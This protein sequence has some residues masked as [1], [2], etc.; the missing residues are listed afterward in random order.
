MIQPVPAGDPAAAATRVVLLGLLA[1]SSALLVG[2]LH[3]FYTRSR[4][5]EGLAVLVG[6]SVVA[7]YL[8]TTAAL[9]EV[10]ADDTDL[11]ALGSALFNVAAFGLAG[12]AAAAGGRAGDRL[13]ESLV[14]LSD[15]PTTDVDVSGLVT[16][17]GRVVTVD[18]PT[19]IEDMEGYDPVDPRTKETLAGATLV[20]PR[21]LTV[22][23]LRER[24]VARL[25]DDYGVGHV[26]LELTADGTVTYLAVG[27]R[28]AGIG[29]TLPP[30]S[31]AV[32][33]RADP[34]NAASAGDLVQVYAPGPEPTRVATAEVRGTASDVVTLAVDAAD[35]GT[36]DGET[37]YR[38]VTLP[39]EPRADREFASLLRSVEET[40]GVATVDAGSSLVGQPVSAVDAAVVAIRTADGTI[41]PIPR[42]SRT[43]AAGESV[44]AIARPDRLRRLDEAARATPGDAGAEGDGEATPSTPAGPEDR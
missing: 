23:E 9:G 8:N 28:E 17:V 14:A 41:E 10:I 15:S 34:A 3:R 26:D 39:V 29:P 44:Y 25:K 22:E 11:L 38:L 40:M 4:V 2:L 6:L 7:L 31:C 19:E 12:L 1:G 37:R 27:A 21:R 24:L 43:I 35:A 18:F 32:A 30:E 16:S 5:P 36:L 33:V 20:F 42:R 13:G